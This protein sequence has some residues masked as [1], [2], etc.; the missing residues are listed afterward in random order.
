MCVVALAWN[1]HPQWRVI[2]AGNRDEFHARPAAALERWADLPGVIAGRDLTGGGTWAGVSEAGR[3]AVIVNVRG[4]PPDPAKLSRGE[5]VTDALTGASVRDFDAYNPFAM[6][7]IDGGRAS[8][9]TNAPEGRAFPLPPGLHGLSNGQANETWPRKARLQA[10][11]ARWL[12]SGKADPAAL[13]EPL[14]DEQPLG[15]GHSPIFIRNVTYGTRASTVFAIDL[16]G[17]GV[18]IER[19][20]GPEGTPL[21]DTRLDFGWPERP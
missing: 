4:N 8:L 9:A 6:F 1:A 20:F 12:E 3:L 10:A 2:M 18:A 19:R 17:R 11:L 5:L 16:D 21:G 14:S 7:A 15:E 13:L